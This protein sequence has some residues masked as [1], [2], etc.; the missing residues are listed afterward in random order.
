MKYQFAMGFLSNLTTW[1]C[2]YLSTQKLVQWAF[3]N[4]TSPSLGGACA[5]MHN[6]S[7][8]YSTKLECYKM[9]LLIMINVY[10]PLFE[11]N[12]YWLSLVLLQPKYAI[13]F[14]VKWLQLIER[15]ETR[16]FLIRSMNLGPIWMM[17]WWFLKFQK[18]KYSL[19]EIK[20]T[21]CIPI[22]TIQN[23]IIYANRWHI[24]HS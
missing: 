14:C 1:C 7:C 23:L 11:L 20:Q 9:I 22:K 15:L 21:D 3:S 19:L 6:V 24:T 8:V 13:Y 2:E 12:S 16:W 18:A 10:F 4:L 5:G 17:N